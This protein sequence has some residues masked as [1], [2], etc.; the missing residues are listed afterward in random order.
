MRGGLRFAARQSTCIQFGAPPSEEF[1]HRNRKAPWP[2]RWLRLYD[3]GRVKTAMCPRLA[4]G[5]PAG[6]GATGYLRRAGIG[7]GWLVRLA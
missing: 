6:S 2:K 4:T 3:E 1:C 5:I 7:T